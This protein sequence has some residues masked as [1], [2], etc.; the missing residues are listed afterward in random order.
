MINKLKKYDNYIFFIIVFVISLGMGLCV[1]VHSGDEIWNFNNAYKIYNGFKMYKDINIIITPLFYYIIS[2]FFK[3]CGANLFIFR[4]IGIL[5]YSFLNVLIYWILKEMG[6][7]KKNAFAYLMILHDTIFIMYMNGANYNFLA[8]AF[9]LLGI[10]FMIKKYD[11]WFL[12]G[13]AAFLVLFTKQNVGIY[14]II[15]TV[16]ITFL[17]S[18]F[19]KKSIIKI[20]KQNT[21]TAIL[22]L[23]NLLIFYYQGI[24]GDF[25]SYTVLGIGEFT[26]NFHI[27]IFILT[28]ISLEIVIWVLTYFIN[29]KKLFDEITCRN[30]IILAVFSTVLILVVYPI[31]NEYHICL[32][33]VVLAI[34]LLAIIHNITIKNFNLDKLIFVLGIIF[35]VKAIIISSLYTCKWLKKACLDVPFSDPYYGGIIDEKYLDK[36]RV[37]DDFIIEEEKKGNNVIILSSEASYYFIPLKIN[38]GIFD[39][40]F[41]GNLGKDNEAGLIKKISEL[42][43]CKI[44]LK[45]GKLFWQE[46]EEANEYVR[47]NFTKVGEIE[48]FEIYE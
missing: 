14:Y 40:P 30:Y 4:I 41:K 9:V 43:N 8:I 38:N 29:K 21:I 23:I 1:S 34:A 42:K 39:L 28:I 19:N 20:I 13:I 36:L 2:F 44:L 24:L 45:N 48:N 35:L 17:I 11:S 27:N 37:V 33:V 12:Q 10:L 22:V 47:N 7:N 32:A 6:V 15:S 26:K 18:G 3:L 46:S 16:I 5:M 25:I 31:A